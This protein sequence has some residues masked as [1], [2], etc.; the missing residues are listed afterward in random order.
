MYKKLVLFSAFVSGLVL[1]GPAS[2][3]PPVLVWQ[4]TLENDSTS[5]VDGGEIVN[6]PSSYIPGAKGNAFAGN[7]NVYVSWDNSEVAAIF[8]DVWDNDAGSTIDL[9]FR[10]DDW[11]THSG[12]SGF[13]SVTDRYGGNDGYFIVSVRDGSLR[14]PWKDSYSGSNHTPHLTGITLANDTTYRLTVRQRDNGVGNNDFEVFLDGGAYSNGSPI[15]TENDW[16]ETIS[17]PQ[18]NAIDTGDWT[19]GGR[20]MAVGT[21]AVFGG[22][23]QSGEWVDHVRVYNGYYTPAELDIPYA[24]NPR[25]EMDETNVLP[26]V[27]LHW[28]APDPNLISD[29][30]ARY[31]VYFGTEPNE[32]SP[33]FPW[34]SENQ[35]ET[36][37]DPLGAG[38]LE[39]LTDYYWRIDVVDPNFGEAIVYKGD[40]WHFTTIPPKATEPFPEDNATGVAQNVVL[41]WTPGYEA[42]SHNVYISTVQSEVETGTA[43][44]ENVVVEEYD[45]PELAWQTEYFWRVDEVFDDGVGPAG[46]VWRFTTGTPE[47]EYELGGDIIA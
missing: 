8:D 27:V 40:L 9:Y 38:L 18:A 46:D 10:G 29:L 44:M 5:S 22:T 33:T 3:A 1:V 37:Y 41:S 36:F 28:D 43:A 35:L 20:Y 4:N 34:V 13:W 42:I 30:P 17:F 11:D 16:N 39:E 32:L 45:P 31:N 19:Q 25:P 6:P 21:R 2:A 26:D 15:Y 24:S 14:F 12:D 23:L 7:G 47:C